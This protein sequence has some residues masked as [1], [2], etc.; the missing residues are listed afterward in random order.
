MVKEAIENTGV[1][2]DPKK[3]AEE[4]IKI[5]DYCRKVKGFEGIQLTWDIEDGVPT[6]KGAFLFVI[7]NGVKEFVAETK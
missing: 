2:G 4:R 5:R 7:K 3:L 1:T 6:A